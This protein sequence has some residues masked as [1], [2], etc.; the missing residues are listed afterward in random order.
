MNYLKN[1]YLYK[2]LNGMLATHFILSAICIGFANIFI[3][4]FIIGFL[5]H[6]SQAF[7]PNTW[8]PESSR[9]YL[10][11]SLL[12]FLFGALFTFFYFKV[13][14]NYVVEG[15]IWSHIKLGL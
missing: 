5:F 7:T 11:S 13:G 3:E 12:S 2:N 9:S 10:Y 14:V 1:S 8:K 6:K 4:W 15:S